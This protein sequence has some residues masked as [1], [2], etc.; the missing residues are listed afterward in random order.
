MQFIL[1]SDFKGIIGPNTLASLR[2]AADENLD[3]A[4][5]LA[6]SE[7]NPLRANF[8]IDTELSRTGDDRNEVLVRM[9]VHITVY[10]LFNAVEDNDIPER[11][12]TNYNNQLKAIEKI[13]T[14]KLSSTIDPLYDEE[15]K[16]KGNYRFGGDAPRDHNIF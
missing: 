7:L 2:G 3:S 11:V 8:D 4:E 1:E 5:D 12:E 9:V 16:P 15:S 13:A 14:G 10:Y 6:L